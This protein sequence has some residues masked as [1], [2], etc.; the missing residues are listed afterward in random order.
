MLANS[1]VLKHFRLLHVQYWIDLGWRVSWWRSLEKTPPLTLH[2]LIVSQGKP[3]LME[4]NLSHASEWSQM[5][6]SA[7]HG[8]VQADPRDQFEAPKEKM[9]HWVFRTWGRSRECPSGWLWS[10]ETWR[11]EWGVGVGFWHE[12]RK[13]AQIFSSAP[14]HQGSS[15]QSYPCW[16]YVCMG[17]CFCT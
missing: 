15:V 11:A 6:G 9:T 16:A 4:V 5:R 7:N 1:G 14:K 12:W 8:A 17:E 3:L 10:F 13:T 2:I